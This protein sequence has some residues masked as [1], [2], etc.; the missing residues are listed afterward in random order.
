MAKGGS[1]R[2]ANGLGSI[3]QR[4]NGRWEA[5]YTL[6]KDPGTGKQIQKSIYGESEDEVRKKLTAA[7]AAIDQGTYIEPSKVSVGE[8]LDEWI[9]VYKSDLTEG[10]RS[11]YTSDIKNNIKP[12]IGSIKLQ[13]LNPHQIQKM[14]NALKAKHAKKSL[15]CIKGTL[16]AA[17]QQAYYNGMIASNPADKVTV[18]KGGIAKR[19]INPLTQGQVD[20]FLKCIKGSEY[21]FVFKAALFTGMRE[22]ELMGLCWSDI[23]FENGTITIDHQMKR[24]NGGRYYLDET[25]T[26]SVRV[27]SPGASVMKMLKDYKKIQSERILRAGNLWDDKEFPGLVFTNAFG[28]FYGKNTL[29]HNVSKAAEKAGVKKFRFHDLR[30]TF[31]T[32]WLANGGD[33]FT[34]SKV[35]GHSTI[36][37]TSDTYSHYTEDIRGRASQQM[38]AYMQKLAAN[39]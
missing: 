30:H 37:L 38:E 31:A 20:V 36:R 3:R 4:P 29:L 19:D 39:Q 17:L 6:G 14:L 9:I 12:Y 18:P 28:K 34:L 2:C 15:M 16:H 32:L 8:W 23:D 5:R 10:A 7:T 35:L 11:K 26:H 13:T 21:E 25:K 33:L 24:G 1:K 27:I 22:G